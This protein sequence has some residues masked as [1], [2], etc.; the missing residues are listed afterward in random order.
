[1]AVVLA[2][3]PFLRS[4]GVPPFGPGLRP[5]SGLLGRLR[6][7]ALRPLVTGALNNAMVDR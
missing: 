6:D 7:E 2:F 5:W 1:M 4:R 3:P